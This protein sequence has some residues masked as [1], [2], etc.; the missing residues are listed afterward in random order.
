MKVRQST[1]YGPG[2]HLNTRPI[3]HLYCNTIISPDLDASP[4]PRLGHLWPRSR[5][6]L[7]PERLG[8]GLASNTLTNASVSPRSRAWTSRSRPR[9][10]LGRPRAHHCAPCATTA[11]ALSGDAVITGHYNKVPNTAHRHLLLAVVSSQYA[12]RIRMWSSL[13]IRRRTLQA[14]D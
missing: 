13:W 1:G 7:G 9:S 12:N 2:Q 14:I 5:L 4:R 10:R 8:L 6:G 11:Y 3:G